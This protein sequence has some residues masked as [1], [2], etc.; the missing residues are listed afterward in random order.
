[1]IR[2]VADSGSTKTDW[3]LIFV[4]VQPLVFSTEGMNPQLNSEEELR[5]KMVSA[6]K[7]HAEHYDID[8]VFFYGAGCRTSVVPMVERVLSEI[9]CCENVSVYSDMLGAARSIC[10]NNPGIV[11]ILGT[12]SNSCVY[13]GVEITD[14]IPPLGYVLGDEGSGA[15]IG[16]RFLGDVYKREYPQEITD[17]IIS[18]LNCSLDEILKRVYKSEN[19]NRFC[20]SM[21]PLV[22]KYLN[23]PN[24]EAM[25][26]DEFCS[27]IQRNISKY[28]EA[29]QLPVNFIGSVAYHFSTQ[30][31]TAME[32]SGYKI[33]KIKQQPLEGII[34][35]HKF[36][37]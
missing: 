9:L 37:P 19:A 8:E 6:L 32:M 18:D 26:I 16:K 25:V 30:V 28:A 27:F 23:C 5:K 35:Y 15:S 3:A 31:A 24:V 2:L 11:G 10:G 14:N 34:D 17:S 12:G 7:S 1:M 20:A 4:D 33:G 22:K 29:K 13:N 21:V 36:I